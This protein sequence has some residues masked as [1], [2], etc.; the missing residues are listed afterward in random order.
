MI[1]S[2]KSF[3]LFV[4]T[5]VATSLLCA[6]TTAQTVRTP[7]PVVQVRPAQ[8]AEPTQPQS[9]KAQKSVRK[10]TP[11]PSRVT[12]VKDQEPVAPQ[13][14]T[15]VHRLSGVK[16]LRYL[17]RN[18]PGSVATISPEDVNADAHASIIAGVAL[19][20][21][22]TIVARLP[23]VAAEMEVQ[24]SSLLAPPDEPDESRD[25]AHR[26]L[27]RAPRMQPDLTVM[28]QDGKTFRARYIGV[29]GLT[30]LSVL[31]LTQAATTAEISG[32]VHKKV[33][34]G[35]NV[36]LFAPERV[37]TETPYTILV[38]IGM[39]EA[40]IA[41]AKIKT[42][43]DLERLLLRGTHLSP[44]VIGGVACDQA[45]NTLGIVDAI[46]GNNAR[47]LT[48]DAVRAATKRVIERQSSV[49]RPLLGIRGEEIDESAKK[50]L[51][52]FGWSE[53]ELEDLI[54]NEV[55]ILLTSV[56]P[57]TPAAMAKLKV[58]DV[59]VRVNGN[60][61]KG[62]EEF[63]EMLTKVGS[64]EDVKFTVERPKLKQSLSI[65][66]KLGGAFQPVF[67]WQF[68][69]PKVPRWTGGL[70]TLGIEAV[71]LSGKYI[72]E[73]GGSGVLVVG[74]EPE[75][76]AARAGLKERDVIEMI[77]GRVV[78][79]GTWPFTYRF[80]SKEKHV[81]SVVRHKEKKQLVI[82]PVE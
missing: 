57:G 5:C 26:R 59:I 33:S 71:T 8:T 30:G 53:Q 82:E 36:Q 40:K 38:R 28:T 43:A 64:G 47:L 67:E 68:E 79:R 6:S 65:E 1:S 16:L 15:I 46:E 58:G 37:S 2:L 69:M 60:D 56:L 70:K 11:R 39:T 29:D 10:P 55:G 50:S 54:E 18:E 13:V 23:Q 48:A 14:V 17:L 73:W 44:N 25:A 4:L 7:A 80:N 81:L 32:A 35:Q 9:P 12:M 45:G 20:D 49:P 24:R 72:S 61:I 41:Q 19:E 3:G 31:Q 27:P 22:K 78:G 74:V 62:A 34:D 52:A 63:S 76:A 75:S 21:G 42:K 51:M 77:N 66:V